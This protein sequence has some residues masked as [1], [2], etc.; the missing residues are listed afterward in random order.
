MRL[1]STM[2][3]GAACTLLLGGTALAQQTMKTEGDE[4]YATHVSAKEPRGQ[5]GE[6]TYKERINTVAR[7]RL[8]HDIRW[9]DTRDRDEWQG[10][11]IWQGIRDE[12]P[13]IARKTMGFHDPRPHRPRKERVLMLSRGPIQGP[14]FAE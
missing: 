11:T 3:I 4:G 5:L 1:R 7:K 2:L 9:L 12:R 6:K 10:H 13:L 8:N 14:G